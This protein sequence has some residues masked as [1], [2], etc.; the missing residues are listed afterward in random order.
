MDLLTAWHVIGH[1]RSS[2]PFPSAVAD[3]EPSAVAGSDM[4]AVAD[5]APSAVA[6]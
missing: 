5:P 2:G 6:D 4:S 3:S 1:V